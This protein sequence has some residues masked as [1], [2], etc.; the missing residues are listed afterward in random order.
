MRVIFFGFLSPMTIFPLWL[1]SAMNGQP[2]VSK[3]PLSA[4]ALKGPFRLG[5]LGPITPQTA[6]CMAI[7]GLL[8]ACAAPIDLGKDVSAESSKP[9]AFLEKTLSKDST[10]SRAYTANEL[11]PKTQESPAFGGE[12]QSFAWGQTVPEKWWTLFGSDQLNALVSLALEKNPSLA[13]ANASLAQAQANYLA[14]YGTLAL[15]NVNTQVSTARERVSQSTSNVPGGSLFN[16]YNASINV[17]Y[18]VDLFGANQ[19]TLEG[20]KALIDLQNYQWRAAQLSVTGN[21]LTAAIKEASIKAQIEETQEILRLQEQQLEIMRRQQRLGAI[22]LS[23]I[24]AQEGLIAQTRA[25]LPVLEKSWELVKSQIAV[26]SGVLPNEREYPSIRIKDLRL[27]TQLPTSLP[28]QLIAHRP[29]ILASQASLN[30]AVANLGLAK[31]NLYPQI[32]L[33]GN[34]GSVATQSNNLF[35]TP[36]SFWTLGAGL[37]APLFNGGALNAKVSA[38]KANYEGAYYQYK[39]TVLNAFENVNDALN[40]VNFDSQS[41][42]L[43]SQSEQIAKKSLELSQSQYQLGAITFMALL[44]AQRTYAQARLNLI[45]AQANRF[46]DTVALIQAMGGEPWEPQ[47][48]AQASGHDL[49]VSLQP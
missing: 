29:D 7:C 1:V 37:T 39:S 4:A 14:S 45:S 38:A 10:P 20:Q 3:S 35:S 49:K 44:D 24:L 19:A 33:N 17:S 21:I 40:A 2:I 11:A 36:F 23:P 25:S 32:N 8:S 31:A 15:P 16:L 26:L 48:T 28:S 30:Q 34:L 42:K 5:S 47:K 13:S 12:S 41:L 9:N 46:A 22:A 6:V 18:T 43:V 27:P